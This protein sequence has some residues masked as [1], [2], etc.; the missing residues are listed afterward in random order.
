[1]AFLPPSPS[2][3]PSSPAPFTESCEL[4]FPE[5]D[6]LVSP[7]TSLSEVDIASSDSDHQYSPS[8]SISSMPVANGSPQPS[9]YCQSSPESSPFS[10]PSSPNM[11]PFPFAQS[12]SHPYP[13]FSPESPFS[14][15]SFD[16]QM[17]PSDKKRKRSDDSTTVYL[18]TD[19]GK[20]N[21][22]VVLSAEQLRTMTSAQF[23][24]F[25][26]SL[27]ANYSLTAADRKEI[28]RQ[29]RLIRN[30]EYAQRKRLSNKEKTQHI[31]EQV[32]TQQDKIDKLEAENGFLKSELFR[33]K[34]LLACF[35]SQDQQHLLNA[36]EL[37]LYMPQK[38]RRIDESSSSP[39][40]SSSAPIVMFVLLF[41]IG[42]IFTST[43]TSISFPNDAKGAGR[44]LLSDQPMRSWTNIFSFLS[45]PSF[46]ISFSLKY[47]EPPKQNLPHFVEEMQKALADHDV[48]SSSSSPSIFDSSP[49]SYSENSPYSTLSIYGLCEGSSLENS[50]QALPPTIVI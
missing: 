10:S 18:E 41:S 26:D 7:L 13:S 16:S 21:S 11:A 29:K 32:E 14:P 15:P 28:Q 23:S 27:K 49:S 20:P 39:S 1:M 48:V 31:H 33:M 38:K 47:F 19:D 46:E 44:N 50:T 2:W 4:M 8:P 24:N 40:S 42:I 17:Q 36:P 37:P 9:L 30:R 34:S 22:F 6:E 25:V 5:I 45:L 43:T 35:L 12:S 3:F